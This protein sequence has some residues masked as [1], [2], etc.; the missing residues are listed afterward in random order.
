MRTIL[1]RYKTLKGFEKAVGHN[2]CN[3]DRVLDGYP[4][5]EYHGKTLVCFLLK[6]DET[7]RKEVAGLLAKLWSK[8]YRNR[9]IE[10]VINHRGDSSYL[11]RFYLEHYSGRFFI[12]TSL[13][14]PNYDYC[15]RMWL[16]S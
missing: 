2:C 10:K 11:Q 12:G 9:V 3:L 13:S 5:Y 4:K 1:R 14:G 8:S 6:L 15:R 7:A 16:K